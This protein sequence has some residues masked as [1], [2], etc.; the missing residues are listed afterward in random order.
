[1]RIFAIIFLMFQFSVIASARLMGCAAIELKVTAEQ[2]GIG[3]R[4]ATLFPEPFYLQ[5][6]TYTSDVYFQEAEFRYLV[7]MRPGELVAA[8]DIE[9][10]ITHL[11]KKSKFEEVVLTC[12]PHG[13]G[14]SIH[15][16]LIGFWTISKLKLHG[17][18]L[19]KEGYRKYYALDIGERFDQ[20]K[21]D[22]SIAKIK[23]AFLVQGYCNAIIESKIVRDDAT[24]TMVVHLFLHKGVS[25]LVGDVTLQVEQGAPGDASDSSQLQAKLYKRFFKKMVRARYNKQLLNEQIRALK[26][27]L[28]N[29]GFIHVIVDLHEKIGAHNKHID[30]T[31][32]V[33]LQ[34]KKEF[35]FLGNRF[36]SSDQLL[37][38][39]SLFGRSVWLLPAALLQQDILE[40]YRKRGFWDAAIEVREEK[41]RCFFIINEGMRVEVKSVLLQ[42]IH[43]TDVVQLSKKYFSSFIKKKEYDMA[44]LDACCNELVA[45]YVS[46]GFL[47]AKVSHISCVKKVHAH[48]IVVTLHEGERS[49][50]TSIDIPG[51]E[52]L[53]QNPFFVDLFQ[54]DQGVPFSTD[55][56]LAQRTWLLQYCHAQ[57]YADI[58]ITPEIKRDA[59][60]I[61]I[62]WNIKK[63]SEKEYFGKTVIVG[64]AT[65]PF[66]YIMRELRYA[67]GDVLDRKQLKESMLRLKELEIFDSIQLYPQRTAVDDEPKTVILKIQKDDPFELRVRVG[68]AAQQMSK[69]LRNAGL[70]YR[71]GGSFLI[72]N[73]FNY[74]DQLLFKA[75]ATRSQRA[76]LLQYRRPWIFNIPI[77]TVF[78][79]YSNR[80]EQPGLFGTVKNLYQVTQQGFLLGGVD[81]RQCL[82]SSVNIG[83]EWVKTTVCQHECSSVCLTENLAHAI[84]FTPRL[85]N[86]NIPYF[87]IEPTLFIDCLDNRLDPRWGSSTLLSCKSMIPMDGKYMDSYFVR[88]LM[89]QSLVRSWRSLVVACRLRVGHI[90]HQELENIM[91]IERF[92]LGGANSIRSYETDRCP[93]LGLYVDDTGC[94]QFVP[95]GGKTMVNMNFELRFPIY[96]TLRGVVFQDLGGLSSSWFRDQERFLVAGTGFGLRYTTPI[97]PVR[98]DFAWKWRKSHPTELPYAWFVTLGHAF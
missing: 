92:Y 26:R 29:K 36:F 22:H 97:G 90:F 3:Q 10:A 91:P 86:K 88:F 96:K 46:Q 49:Y 62:V 94:P 40:L 79:L 60:Q 21:H 14:M 51:Y 9:R 31:F 34:K 6:I 12:A 65:F 54:S 44:L 30:L 16:T 24:K 95:R 43:H 59:T 8:R 13:N 18:L 35:V 28:F 17:M 89:E 75:D 57:G 37:D 72:K 32:T 78:Q 81:R 70:T 45:W 64:S 19:G 52:Y 82:E 47:E 53:E 4:V 41:E 93:P 27:Y 69:S 58:A 25:F 56:L 39:I 11:F 77:R 76:T 67:E 33:K 38:H 20:T 84:Q 63:T 73:P 7:D 15:M 2:D 68:F 87:L 85:L 1:M 66:E 61:H 71:A 80:Y 42:G 50:I 5:N 74:A 48:E 98:F 55:L 83:V 23:E